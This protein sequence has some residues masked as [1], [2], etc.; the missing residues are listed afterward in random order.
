MRYA[1]ER[2]RTLSDFSTAVKLKCLLTCKLISQAHILMIDINVSLMV[3]FHKNYVGR[4]PE[5]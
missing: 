1:P 3:F 4:L 5:S 2:T